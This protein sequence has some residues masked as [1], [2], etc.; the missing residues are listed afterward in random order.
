[1]RFILTN[2]EEYIEMEHTQKQQSE[3]KSIEI[4]FENFLEYYEIR[5]PWYFWLITYVIL[6]IIAIFLTF[7]FSIFFFNILHPIDVN[8][9]RYLLSSLIQS[10]AAII[11]IVVTLTLI[12]VQTTSAQY[13][14]RVT[15][16]YSQS[17]HMF[18]LLISY[19][20]SITF[21][22]VLLQLL[23]D[24]E[25]LIP[26]L[27]VFFISLSLWLTIVLAVALIPYF[28]YSLESLNPERITKKII[29][30]LNENSNISIG[31]DR[32]S[33]ELVFVTRL[34]QWDQSVDQRGST[35]DSVTIK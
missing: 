23:V 19:I 21:G 20:L 6:A 30:T 34:D 2:N 8:S 17:P 14:P 33:F 28:F 7:V 25:G 22:A 31:A 1:M 10:Q 3:K 4:R 32:D 26:P 27:Y 11:A 9:A 5:H 15:K 35:V 29:G 18:L 24:V 12:A 16:I 13:S